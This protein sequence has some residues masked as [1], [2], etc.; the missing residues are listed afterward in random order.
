MIE[1]IT[2]NAIASAGILLLAGLL[3]AACYHKWGW[4]RTGARVGT[5]VIGITGTIASGKSLVGKLLEKMGLP[6][7]DTDHVAHHVLKNDAD[8]K[9]ALR[10]RFGTGIFGADGHINRKAL[11]A[12]V[13]SDDAARHD[14]DKI[15]HPAV[16]KACRQQVYALGPVPL[17]FLLVPLLFEAGLEE[18]YDEIWTVIASPEVVRE[19]LKKRDGLTDEEAEKR[20]AAQYP[21]AEKARRSHHVIDNSGTEDDTRRQVEFLLALPANQK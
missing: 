10:K 18:Q 5:K 20:I 11:G 1:F 17:V 7:I 2:A 19:R 13:F 16:I 6:V 12:I 15:V 4:S 3:A 8:V 21:Q 9:E 14:L